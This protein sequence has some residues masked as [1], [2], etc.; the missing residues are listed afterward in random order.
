MT[1]Q[2]TPL[3]R[4][5]ARAEATGDPADRLAFWERLAEAELS[6][7]LD[8]ETAGDTVTP[9]LFEVEGA[10]YALAFDL[11]H[12]LSAFAGAAPTATLSGRALARLLAAESLG[13]GLNLDD[14][15]S[16]QLIEPASVAWLAATLAE[17]PVEDAARI[18][19][20]GP[21]GALPDRLLT[22]L[23]AK[24]PLM[25]G[26]ARAAYLA[27]VRYEGGARSHVLAFLDAVPG[28]EPD[29]A[30]AVNEALVFTGLDAG[31][32][33]VTFVRAAQPLSAALARHGLRIELPEPVRAA[34]DPD[35]PPR[36][37]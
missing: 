30:R 27:G 23:D 7:L 11:A 32:L 29:L 37:R 33:D 4:A 20:V 26:L 9:R 15:P 21:P 2:G 28:A 16:A 3:D 8:A 13:L 24:L 1:D 17:A 31:T 12:R 34:P 22:A 14:A 5:H 19:E 18:E 35:A 36:L 6:L 25:A 10:S